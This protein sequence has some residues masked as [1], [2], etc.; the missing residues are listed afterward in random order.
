MHHTIYSLLFLGLLISCADK[1]KDLDPVTLEDK[2]G[3]E[4]ATGVELLYSDSAIVRVRV[5]APVMLHHKEKN[6]PKQVFPKGIVADIFNNQHQQ[7]SKLRSQYAEQFTKKKKVYLKK[8]VHVWNTK[9]EH[10]EAEK[11][12]WDESQ[13]MI[14]SDTFVKITT[15]TQII[16]GH[17]LKANLD[18]TEWSIDDV[19]GIVESKDIV[20]APF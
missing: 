9:N 5:T 16:T 13:E 8:K 18:F 7:T 14:Y 3:I 11:L 4:R 20:D 6:N 19:V 12:I 15:P 17:R 10:L 1:V 2:A